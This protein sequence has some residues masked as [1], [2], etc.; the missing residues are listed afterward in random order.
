MT[1]KEKVKQFQGLTKSQKQAVLAA[2]ELQTYLGLTSELNLSE[3]VKAPP[4][5]ASQLH[6]PTDKFVKQRTPC[7]VQFLKNTEIHSA[8]H[9]VG[10]NTLHVLTQSFA[11]RNSLSLKE[12]S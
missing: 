9:T 7:R 8:R 12:C 10:I 6:W 11:I 1:F 4:F 3:I 2:A 5:S